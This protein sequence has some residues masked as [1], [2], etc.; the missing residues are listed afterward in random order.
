[1]AQEVQKVQPRAVWRDHN[2]YLV[3]N[4]DR[5]GLQFMTWKQWLA[6]TSRDD[7]R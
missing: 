3:V 6:R 4:Y 7:E 1:M 2:G 5:I